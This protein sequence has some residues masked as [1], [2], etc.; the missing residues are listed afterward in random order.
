MRT[1]LSGL[2]AGLIVLSNF[3]GAAASLHHSDSFERR[4]HHASSI[5]K[6]APD[7]PVHYWE[8]KIRGVSL[9]GWLT[10]EPWITPSI[11][12][13]QENSNIVDEYT[14]AQYGNRDTVH[15]ALVNHWSSFITKDDFQKI[16]DAGLNH[17]KIPI[18]YW[19]W[20]VSQG[21]PYHQGQLFY[22]DQA[23]GWARDLGLKV[24]ITLQGLPGSQN[25]FDGSGQKGTVNWHE[26][27]QNVDRSSNIVKVLASWYSAQ[28]DVVVAIESIA[29][30]AGWT[31][32]NFMQVLRQYYLDSYGNIRYPYATASQGAIVQVI[33]D[34]GMS[35]SSWRGFAPPASFDGVM[36]DTHYYSIWCPDCPSRTFDQHIAAVCQQNATLADSELWTVVGEWTLSTTDCAN[37]QFA[38]LGG[39]TFDGSAAG[40]SKHGD[41][42]LMTGDGSK[43]SDDFKKFMRMFFEAQT[44][45]F[46]A[47]SVGWIYNTWKTESAAESSYSA[48]L[49]GG[50]IPSDV[51]QR[52]YP[53]ICSGT[54]FVNATAPVVNVTAP[55][56][57]LTTPVVNV[58][59]PSANLTTPVVNN[60]TTLT[61]CGR[62]VPQDAKGV[63]INMRIEGKTR[64]VYEGSLF[65]TVHNFTL[66]TPN[67]VFN[68]LHCDGTNSGYKLPG[69]PYTTSISA[70]DDASCDAKFDWT[71]YLLEGIDGPSTY[72]MVYKSIGPADQN[73][74]SWSA[75]I[76]DVLVGDP[77][78]SPVKEGDEVIVFVTDGITYNPYYSILKLEGG[79]TGT[80]GQPIS[81]KITDRK[82]S[83]PAGGAIV[84]E[85]DDATIS[86]TAGSDGLVSLT[87]NKAGTYNVK[88][89]KGGSVRSNRLTIVVTAAP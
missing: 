61:R 7:W 12:T 77:C 8:T 58:T 72:S 76:S 71:G 40:S 57:N 29:S 82:S 11:F 36:I 52:V 80:V 78:S 50:W 33:A 39:S 30:P 75:Y 35:L 65:T 32:D 6:R 31:G 19:A 10:L 53:N 64:T 38:A 87:F 14:L 56:T 79:T 59:S 86:G 41:C 68:D 85:L 25:G 16:K 83:S 23:V 17:V 69:A 63:T 42:S 66:T 26:N 27:K 60:A 22:L 4:A 34:A 74:Q 44:S 70:I 67:G 24:M 20:D 88:A 3:S 81:L 47:N 21:E 13:S 1:S 55:S 89:E 49:A 54:P 9:A 5:S 51:T 15:K 62:V 28:T 37:L 45:T 84:T 48:G 43:F 18:G 2:V 73:G 46:E